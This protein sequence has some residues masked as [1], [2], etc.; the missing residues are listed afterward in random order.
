MCNAREPI[1]IG[2][3]WLQQEIGCSSL[4]VREVEGNFFTAEHVHS[5]A[6]KW[7]RTGFANIW[8]PQ[9]THAVDCSSISETISKLKNIENRSTRKKLE[10]TII[11]IIITS[12]INRRSVLYIL[13]T[14]Q[15]NYYYFLLY[16]AIFH[17]VHSFLSFKN[18]SPQYIR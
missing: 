3:I 6:L 4:S 11:T 9:G 14:V 7:N 1:G 16:Q 5:C 2:S 10:I 12:L 17:S 13:S 18:T 8:N 15:E